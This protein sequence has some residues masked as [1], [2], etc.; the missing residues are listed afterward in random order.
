MAEI[1]D[2]LVYNPDGN[3]AIERSVR[4]RVKVLTEKFPI[5]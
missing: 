4:E 2:S 5:Y 1:L 3:E